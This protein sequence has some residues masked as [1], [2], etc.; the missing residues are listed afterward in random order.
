M[1][2][3]FD[4]DIARAVLVAPEAGANDLLRIRVE[5]HARQIVLVVYLEGTCDIVC[6]VLARP[7]GYQPYLLGIDIET[8]ELDRARDVGC[9]I[10]VA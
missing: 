6:K 4:K 3:R 1:I 10:I 2:G 5:I 9:G 7:V 8:V